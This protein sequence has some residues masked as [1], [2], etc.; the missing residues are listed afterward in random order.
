MMSKFSIQIWM[1]KHD[2][3]NISDLISIDKEW[4]N[5]S[6]HVARNFLRGGADFLRGA[7]HGKKI[8]SAGAKLLSCTPLQ[9]IFFLRGAQAPLATSLNVLWK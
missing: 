4:I 3:K 6:R 2:N 9:G 1:F 5:V 7:H 8:F